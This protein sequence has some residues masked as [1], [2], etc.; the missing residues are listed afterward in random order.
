MCANRKNVN[1]VQWW[2]KYQRTQLKGLGLEYEG[3]RKKK[4]K[5]IGLPL[6]LLVEI[7]H[8]HSKRKGLGKDR[9]REIGP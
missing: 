3:Q 7:V 4:R 9:V 1:A 6:S 8:L 5:K 2:L